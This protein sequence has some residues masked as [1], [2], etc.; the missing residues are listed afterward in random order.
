MARCRGSRLIQTQ[1]TQRHVQQNLAHIKQQ[2]DFLDEKDITAPQGVDVAVKEDAPDWDDL[3]GAVEGEEGDALAELKER[4]EA[5]NAKH[6]VGKKRARD[7]GEEEERD[8]DDDDDDMFEEIPF[9]DDD[10]EEEGEE[11]EVEGEEEEV[12]GEEDQTAA[13][14]EEVDMGAVV[15]DEGTLPLLVRLCSPAACAL[16][17]MNVL[18]F[19]KKTSL[20]WIRRC[21]TRRPSRRR[22]FA[23][24]VAR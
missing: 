16:T 18:M 1:L 4:V 11:E 9:S 3:L 5:I 23:V 2:V 7:A 19:C 24:E 14:E 15:H 17:V 12:E 21:A 6:N 10:D 22:K 20:L 8:D 13:R